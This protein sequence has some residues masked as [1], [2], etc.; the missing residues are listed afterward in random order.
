MEEQD[1]NQQEICGFHSCVSGIRQ[2]VVGYVVAGVLKKLCV[3]IFEG[4]TVLTSFSSDCFI[5]QNNGI[6]FLQ[7][8]GNNSNSET[9]SCLKVLNHRTGTL[10]K[11]DSSSVR[12]AVQISKR[13]FL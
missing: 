5:L 9:V 1:T 7:N 11:N 4:Q 10:R 3:S 2:R 6:T 13:Q 8:T 12:I